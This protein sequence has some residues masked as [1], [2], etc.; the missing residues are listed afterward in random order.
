MESLKQLAVP[1]RERDRAESPLAQEGILIRTGSVKRQK[2]VIEAKYC[3]EESPVPQSGVVTP[4]L[5]G[6]ITPPIVVIST[7]QNNTPDRDTIIINTDNAL[8][9]SSTLDNTY[10]NN[11]EVLQGQDVIVKQFDSIVCTEMTEK[12]PDECEKDCTESAASRDSQSAYPHSEDIPWHVGTV[13]QHKQALENKVKLLESTPPSISLAAHTAVADTVLEEGKD[14]ITRVDGD[15]MRSDSC[16]VLSDTSTAG[17]VKKLT[18]E[19]KGN[20]EP[21]EKSNCQK[22]PET[23]YEAKDSGTA[24]ASESSV[25]SD[26]TSDSENRKSSV[27]LRD[28]SDK[29]I[30]NRSREE[31]VKSLVEMFEPKDNTDI[32]KKEHMTKRSLSESQLKLVEA[33][34]AM[35][36]LGSGA[37]TNLKTIS[38]DVDN[39]NNSTES[40]DICASNV[41][42]ASSKSDANTITEGAK[43]LSRKPSLPNLLLSEATSEVD[44]SMSRP[45]SCTSPDSQSPRQQETKKLLNRAKSCTEINVISPVSSSDSAHHSKSKSFTS[46]GD[47]C[48]TFYQVEAETDLSEIPRKARKLHGRT[49]P[50]AKLSSDVTDNTSF[51]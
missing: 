8:K 42:E 46:A 12:Q 44:E 24:L 37:E 2:Q 22:T 18:K 7:E 51:K 30:S 26:A 15:L 31:K 43:A 5:T 50:L 16:H 23:P 17:V 33:N 41:Y 19:V 40:T 35:W 29:E 48:Y 10:S 47:G 27:D 32:H 28:A 6:S 25:V 49:H 4:P 20:N 1:I 3:G 21:V 13:M 11:S 34:T 38:M 14:N 9:D 39:K 45:R 36:S